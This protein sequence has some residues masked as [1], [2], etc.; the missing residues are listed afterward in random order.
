MQHEL[1]WVDFL[2]RIFNFIIIISIPILVLYVFVKLISRVRYK[3]T[4]TGLGSAIM[5]CK[6]C[7]HV[8]HPNIIIRGYLTLEIILWLCGIIPGLI[9][10]LWR[11]QNRFQVCP[12]C[13]GKD[14]IPLD[15]PIG[16]QI[17]NQQH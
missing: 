12:L 16:R 4:L 13:R 5:I 3:K 7:G 11:E 1:N 15:S 9:Y 8:D 6:T 2:L 10:T 14:L 17:S